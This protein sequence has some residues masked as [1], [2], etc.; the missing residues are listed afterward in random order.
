[1]SFSS[2]SLILLFLSV[3]LPEQ[4][5]L[6]HC[7]LVLPVFWGFASRVHPCIYSLDGFF[8]FH[9]RL[10]RVTH[11]GMGSCDLLCYCIVIGSI[12]VLHLLI[13]PPLSGHLLF[14]VSGCNRIECCSEHLGHMCT[15]YIWSRGQEWNCWLLL[16]PHTQ[17]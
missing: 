13:H 6:R 12:N 1:M 17:L 7:H 4:C 9:I 10:V 5:L 2:V 8:S 14:P 3:L 15:P 16:C 11:A